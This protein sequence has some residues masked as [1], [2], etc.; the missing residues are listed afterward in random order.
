M[1]LWVQSPATQKIKNDRMRKK[2]RIEKEGNS[3]SEAFSSVISIFLII[4]KN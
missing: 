2:D 4:N 1:M 3:F